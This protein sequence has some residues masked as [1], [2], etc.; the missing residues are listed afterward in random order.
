M[1]KRF[2]FIIGASVKGVNYLT[3]LQVKK[4]YLCNFNCDLSIYNF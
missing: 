3:D 1:I 2:S 4:K